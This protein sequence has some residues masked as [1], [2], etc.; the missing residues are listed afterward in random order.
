MPWFL[1][2]F[3][4]VNRSA[5][6]MLPGVSLNR[7]EQQIF[8]YIEANREERQY[9]QNKVRGYR[10]TALLE[11]DIVVTVERELWRYF[12]ERSAVVSSL[13]PHAGTE[14][15]RVSMKNLAEYILRL[16]APPIP[17][18]KAT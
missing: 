7:S 16:W 6:C 4:V 3:E 15:Q 18:R 12:V 14:V 8:N 13:K 2:V 17:K 9:W 10:T 5:E 11:G 1:L